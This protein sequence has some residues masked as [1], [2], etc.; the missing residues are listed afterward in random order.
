MVGGIYVGC[1]FTFGRGQ[2]GRDRVDSDGGLAVSQLKFGPG[3]AFPLEPCWDSSGA[4]GS[5]DNVLAGKQTIV[6]FASWD[7][8]PCLDLLRDLHQKFLKRVHPNA[9]VVV[10]IEKALGSV[11]DEYAGMIR[12]VRLVLIDQKVWRSVYRATFWPTGDRRRDCFT[13]PTGGNSTPPVATR[14]S[15]GNTVSC[16]V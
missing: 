12:G 8:G 6:I 14:N 11:P 4:A 5:M 13:I 10:A 16:V 9:Q 7:C 1:A 2:S 15:C 3:D